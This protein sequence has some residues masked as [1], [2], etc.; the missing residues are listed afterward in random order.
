[1]ALT[2]AAQPQSGSVYV[3]EE[4]GGQDAIGDPAIEGELDHPAAPCG[5]P[6]GRSCALTSTRSSIIADFVDQWLA[7]TEPGTEAA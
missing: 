6:V 7:C 3:E 5:L 4:V 2:G 1:M